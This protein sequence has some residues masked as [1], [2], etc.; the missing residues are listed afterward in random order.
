MLYYIKNTSKEGDK[1]SV[2]IHAFFISFVINIFI[3][4]YSVYS[5]ID[6]ILFRN[7]QGSKLELKKRD[8]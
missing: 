8:I 3:I 6:A 7:E 2:L 5:E 1:L 4:I